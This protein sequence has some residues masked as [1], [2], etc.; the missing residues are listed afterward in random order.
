MKSSTL[1]V[2]LLVA[3]CIAIDLAMIGELQVR[4]N[5]WPEPGGVVGLG[6]SFSQIAL[7]ALWAVWGH[8]QILVRGVGTL[9]GVWAVSC[10]AS[11]SSMGSLG[12]AGDWFGVQL[13]Y[14]GVSLVPFLI[15]R[16]ANYELSKELAR[17]RQSAGHRLSANQFTIWGILSLTTA[18]GIA[19]AVVRFAEFPVGELLEVAAFFTLL[20]AT[21]CGILL[22]ALFLSRVIFAI[23][24]TLV[25]C[26]IAGVLL[27]LTG[28]AP[29]DA[30]ELV[31]M[32]CVQGAVLLAAAIAIKAAG[33]RL[34]RGAGA[35]EATA[36]GS[37]GV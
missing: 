7:L 30:V 18:A 31:L 4:R 15:A 17:S 24:A 12:E 19:L 5:E 23:V 14:C 25:I 11:F 35:S 37:T 29:G 34:V 10:L 21:A 6:L 26:P 28:L 27:S 16:F 32:M 33:F 2:W 20:A 3:A 1:I 13:F 36:S 9:L 22:L 8:N